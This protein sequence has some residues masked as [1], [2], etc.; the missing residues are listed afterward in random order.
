MPFSHCQFGVPGIV[1]FFGTYIK[2]GD[3]MIL[4]YGNKITKL[5][6]GDLRTLNKRRNHNSFWQINPPRRA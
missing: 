1:F 5:T 3:M 2:P 6:G 4:N